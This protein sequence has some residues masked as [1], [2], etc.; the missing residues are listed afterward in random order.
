MRKRQT[1]ED[2]SIYAA[3]ELIARERIIGQVY[4]A[5]HQD[6][7]ISRVLLANGNSLFRT[8]ADFLEYEAWFPNVVTEPQPAVAAAWA[9]R[10][11]QITYDKVAFL[12]PI[13]FIET[14][15]A[16]EPRPARIYVIRKRLPFRRSVMGWFIWQKGAFED[17]MIRWI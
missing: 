1:P 2:G 5:A 8:S 9:R 17:T 4:E 12:L 14:V 13:S 15:E 10:A 11:L 6:E 16:K 3:T 7:G